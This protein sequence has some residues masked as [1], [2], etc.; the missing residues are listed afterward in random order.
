MFSDLLSHSAIFRSDNNLLGG[1]VFFTND[2]VYD[3][4]YSLPSA[5]KYNPGTLAID[6]DGNAQIASGGSFYSGA[7]FWRDFCGSN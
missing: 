2:D 7:D 6:A 1:F 4:K 3:F 5:S